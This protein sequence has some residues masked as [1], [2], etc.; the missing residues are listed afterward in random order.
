MALPGD[1]FHDRALLP[2]GSGGVVV[3][4]RVSASTGVPIATRFDG[5]GVLHVGWPATGLALSRVSPDGDM[6]PM[7]SQLLPSGPGHLLAVWSLDAGSGAR[8][9]MMQRFGLD[10]TL[11]PAWPVDGLEVVAPDTINACRT[12]PDGAGGAY[13]VREAHRRPVDIHI[14]SVGALL[15][16]HSDGPSGAF[17]VWSDYHDLGF[18][19]FSG[20]LWMTCVQV[21]TT[22]GV[23][24]SP[25]RALQFSAPRPNPTTGSVVLDLV[26]PDDSGA[27]VELLDV[28][29][30][31]QRTQ[32]VEGAGD[33]AITFD[34]LG[35]LAPGLYFARLTSR[36]G[37][38]ATRVLVSR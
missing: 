17:V 2:D 38:T 35:S 34:E 23:G 24:T 11:D 30:R 33:H 3:F 21:P 13:V 27:H 22:T 36:H 18:G 37:S 9:L 7:D 20:D 25:P 16:L 31:V 26:L 10:A 29:G 28:S 14:T 15:T 19:Q 6:G 32:V 1:P 4:L 12:I 5:N 8:R